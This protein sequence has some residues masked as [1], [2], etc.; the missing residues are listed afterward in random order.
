MRLLLYQIFNLS[1]IVKPTKN[2][3]YIAWHIKCWEKITLEKKETFIKASY[4]RHK[5]FRPF[6][7]NAQGTPWIL[8]R[9]WLESSGQILISS[10][11]KTKI[12]AFFSYFFWAKKI[13]FKKIQ[14]FQKKSEF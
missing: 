11:G 3:A 13:Y 10:I 12:I 14:I 2:Q 4:I 8:K 6:V 5:D 7:R 1:C 9:G